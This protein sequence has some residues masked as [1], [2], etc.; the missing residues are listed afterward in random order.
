MLPNPGPAGTFLFL[1]IGYREDVQE[2]KKIQSLP[3]NKKLVYHKVVL[4]RRDLTNGFR[5]VL[6]K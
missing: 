2:K 6:K 5:K 4:Q 1:K 3:L